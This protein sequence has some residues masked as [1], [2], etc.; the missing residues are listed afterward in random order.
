MEEDED[1]LASL[2]EAATKQLEN[3]DSVKP[4]TQPNVTH[5]SEGSS[6]KPQAQKEEKPILRDFDIFNFNS[7][8]KLAESNIT[9]EIHNGDTDSSDD[10]GNR[11][12]EDQKYNECGKE[13][14]KLLS[15]NENSISSSH[16]GTPKQ[17]FSTWKSKCV[18]T[19]QQIKQNTLFKSKPEEER[20]F[21]DVL[22]DPIFG[23][24]I[25]NPKIS[26]QMLKE[27]M[28]GRLS[29]RFS[30]LSRLL[31]SGSLK[32][33]DWV[34]CGV[35]VNKSPPKTTQKGTQFSIW[36]LTDLK[37]DIKTVALFM[38]NSAHKEL[39]STA[40]GTVIGVLNPNIMDRRDG[41]KDEAALSVDTSQKIMVFGQSKDFGTCKSIKKNGEKCTS[42]INISICEYCIYHVKQEYQKCSKRSE[43]QANFAGKGLVNLRNKVLGKNEVFY[44]GK[45]FMAI[46]A[47]KSKKLEARDNNIMENLSSMN[48]RAPSSTKSR[49]NKGKKGAATHL[50][51]N[52][53]Q[54]ARDLELLKKLGGVN[55]LETKT[56]F[57]GLRSDKITLEE[58]K[59][60]AREV[61]EKLKV[62]QY[63]S[64]NQQLRKN[65]LY[66]L[67]SDLFVNVEGKSKFLGKISEDVSLEDSRNSALSVISK[68]KAQR[69]N[70]IQSDK[71]NK[72][73]EMLPLEVF[74]RASECNE[75]NYYS[76]DQ[77][78]IDNPD[79]EGNLNILENVNKN[80]SL[81]KTINKGAVIAMNST[82]DSNEPPS[83][84]NSSNFKIDSLNIMIPTRDSKVSLSTIKN[85]SKTRNTSKVLNSIPKSIKTKD[86]TKPTLPTFTKTNFEQQT[87]INSSHM[88]SPL[89][90]L[91]MGIPLLSG[92]G[93]SDLIDLNK[94][95]TSKHIEKA[96]LNAIKYIQR[97]GPI[98]KVDPNCTK[99]KSSSKKRTFDN[100][101][102][103]EA[104]SHL[105]GN[106]LAK[107][108]K[109]EES[110]FISDR[111][112]K[113]MAMTSRHTDLLERHDDEEKEKYFNKQEAKEKMEEKM[114]N[115]HKVKCKAVKCLQCKYTSFSASDLCKTEG[116]TLKVFDSMKR[117]YKC[118]NCQKRITILELIPTR[119]CTNCGS[120][121]WEKTGMMKE[122][123][124]VVQ[125]N[126]SIRGGEQKFIN[127]MAADANLDLLVPD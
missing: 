92:Y 51:V 12:Y 107:K 122:K 65:S 20:K 14:K 36:T 59:A 115:T 91:T 77:N 44:A 31:F 81:T 118:G 9:S 124:A 11:N 97:T 32:E 105:L 21:E 80:K 19:N 23:M 120:S 57:S 121:K 100:M 8:L 117:F 126:L 3:T 39:W 86:V 7:N 109:L 54:R 4:T 108:S 116:H 110:E 71:Q 99:A 84:Q 94:P 104:G 10:E 26:S 29:I 72:F 111:F 66:D 58:S 35:V 33:K 45:S 127:S 18:A 24:R 90:K 68:L 37:D 61:I 52:P 5:F 119:P 102:N 114:I 15:T 83:S 73:D 17:R 78:E 46:P 64:G 95:V 49:V 47:R 63:Q 106:P 96:K 53:A 28:Q 103:G 43:L 67:K 98:K 2:L 85:L 89:D 101:L 38:F 60:T 74:E 34:I 125:H 6:S 70:D 75:L 1:L 30:D 93:C 50:D 41:S 87:P 62:K 123:L 48:G 82:K 56:F 113:M 42:I 112:K 88:K 76:D 40:A 13:I 16:Y 55:N 22:I 25:V 69:A 79:F 27:R